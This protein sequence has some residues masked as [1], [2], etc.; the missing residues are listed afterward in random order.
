MMRK[1]GRR[2][3]TD[4]TLHADHHRESRLDQALR[5]AIQIFIIAELGGLAA[6]QRDEL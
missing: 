2:P 6:A 1:R 4:G 5:H 3:I